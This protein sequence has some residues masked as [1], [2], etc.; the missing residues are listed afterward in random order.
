MSPTCG[1][2]SRRIEVGRLGLSGSLTQQRG[3]IGS[4]QRGRDVAPLPE[5]AAKLDE[6]LQLLLIFD[7]LDH[8]G[9]VEVLADVP[10]GADKRQILG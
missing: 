4:R 8:Q 1:P 9:E 10:H 2:C 5:G 7:P 6:L 3:N